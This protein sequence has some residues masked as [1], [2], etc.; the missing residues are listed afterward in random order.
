MKGR[1]IANVLDSRNQ[2]LCIGS[3][4]RIGSIKRLLLRLIG[5]GT[6]IYFRERMRRRRLVSWICKMNW[7]ARYV[8]RYVRTPEYLEQICSQSMLVMI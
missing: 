6:G 3:H 1:R 7:R 4:I 5:A 2:G 8:C